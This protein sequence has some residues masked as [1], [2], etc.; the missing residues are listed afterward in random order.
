MGKYKNKMQWNLGKAYFFLYTLP[1]I[2]Y[3]IRE[4]FVEE[5]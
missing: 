2:T 1:L 3:V 5:V 4:V